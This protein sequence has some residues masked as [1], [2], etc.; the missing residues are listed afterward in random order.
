MVIASVH[1]GDDVDTCELAESRLRMPHPSKLSVCIH[2]P[3]SSRCPF[4]SRQIGRAHVCFPICV[5]EGD[6]VDTCELA[7]SRLRMPHPSKLSVCIH[8]PSSSRCPFTSRRAFFR[9]LFLA[10][11]E[12]CGHDN[13]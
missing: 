13:C 11:G 5:H 9:L 10:L 12:Q 1:E 8:P 6:D 7:E 3:S 4:T 2:P